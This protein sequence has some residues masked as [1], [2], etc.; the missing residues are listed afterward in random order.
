MTK[1][2]K[3]GARSGMRHVKAELIVTVLL[4]IYA[5]SSV[6]Y[7][8]YISLPFALGIAGLAIAAVLTFRFQQFAFPFLALLL[9]FALPNLVKFSQTGFYIGIGPVG[10]PV[11]PTLLLAYLSYKRRDRIRGWFSDTDETEKEASRQRKLALFR[12]EFNQYSPEEI[13]RKL[14]H[15]V[16]VPEAREVLLE[17]LHTK[18]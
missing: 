6:V 3:T 16:L 10:V 15:D 12:N 17:L 2:T 14:D 11:I 7:I 18:K 13:K 8:H 4:W 5:I 1:E 9:L